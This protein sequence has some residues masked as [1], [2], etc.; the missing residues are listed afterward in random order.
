[1]VIPKSLPFA[2][3]LSL[4]YS[5]KKIT[6][7]NNLLKHLEALKLQE[8]KQSFAWLNKNTDN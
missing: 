3:S 2:V 6:K 4:A 8:M 1:M 7:D 5:V